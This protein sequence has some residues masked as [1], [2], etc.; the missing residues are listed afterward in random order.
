MEYC[1]GDQAEET[2]KKLADKKV[3][4]VE[5]REVRRRKEEAE[6]SFRVAREAQERNREALAKAKEEEERLRCVF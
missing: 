6:R 1:K 4:I 3:E 2:E 5:E